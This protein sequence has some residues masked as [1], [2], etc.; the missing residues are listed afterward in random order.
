MLYDNAFNLD[1]YIITEFGKALAN[2]E[3]DAFLNGD[4]TGKPLGLFAATGGGDVAAT[5][6]AAIKSD[7][8]LDLVYAL[9]RPYRKTASFILNDQI[10]A[11]VRKLKDNNGAYMATT[12][13]LGNLW[14]NTW[15][16]M[17]STTSTFVDAISLSIWNFAKDMLEYLKPIMEFFGMTDTIKNWTA[18]VSQGVKLSSQSLNQ[19]AL[20]NAADSIGMVLGI[21]EA[22]IGEKAGDIKRV[23]SSEPLTIRMLEEINSAGD[24]EITGDAKRIYSFGGLKV[25]MDRAIG[26]AADDEKAGDI[27]RIYTPGGLRV[28][29][30]R[31]INTAVDNEVCGDFIRICFVTL[32]HMET[33]DKKE[34]RLEGLF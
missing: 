15:E 16:W 2:A 1:N 19:S 26:T 8:L 3:E 34:R 27:E 32:A 13:E 11:T 24:K 25:T 4:G 9:K 20:K 18:A 17:K 30:H 6:T 10:L 22:E 28:K 31:L 7:D 14:F 29:M 12:D 5:L 21:N 33:Q 23:Y